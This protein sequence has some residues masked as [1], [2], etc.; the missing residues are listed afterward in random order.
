MKICMVLKPVCIIGLNVK[1]LIM[2][3]LAKRGLMI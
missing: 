1:M 3:N 2:Q